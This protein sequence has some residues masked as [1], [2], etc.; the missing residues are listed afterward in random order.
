MR[1]LIGQPEAMP[2]M[3]VPVWQNGMPQSMQRAPC[4]RSLSSG[5]WWWNSFQSRDALERRAVGGSSRRYSMKP[6]GFPMLSS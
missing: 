6:V 2:L 1:L 5:M 4:L 3:S